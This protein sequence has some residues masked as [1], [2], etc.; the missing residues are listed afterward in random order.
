MFGA[1]ALACAVGIPLGL[2][3]TSCDTEIAMIVPAAM[4]CQLKQA[5]AI[6]KAAEACAA[7]QADPTSRAYGPLCG[8][9]RRY[10]PAI[11]DDKG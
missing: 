1:F 2:A 10:P 3:M 9:T 11:I 7:I 6:A 4:R 5:A 8:S